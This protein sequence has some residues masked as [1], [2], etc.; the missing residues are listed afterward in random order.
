MAASAIL[1]P[2]A[3][4]A[5]ATEMIVHKDPYCGCCEAWASA[6]GAAGFAVTTRNE[7]DMNAVKWRA[8][9]DPKIDSRICPGRHLSGLFCACTPD[10][11]RKV[12]LI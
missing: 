7:E 11:R 5:K 9:S 1:L 3:A 10:E 8:H 4:A 6:Y 2:R 12:R